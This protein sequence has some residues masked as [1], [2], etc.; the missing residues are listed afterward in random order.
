MD[1]HREL[2]SLGPVAGVHV[3]L[4]NPAAK[5]FLASFKKGVVIPPADSNTK[6]VIVAPYVTLS[7]TIA[8]KNRLEASVELLTIR[9]LV[10]KIVGEGSE[11]F[12]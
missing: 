2:L 12:A 8:I 7:N 3:G 10:T 4:R 11:F 9:D 5:S 1:K 6:Y